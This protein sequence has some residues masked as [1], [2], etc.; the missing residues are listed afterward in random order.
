MNKDQVKGAAKDLGGKIQEEVGK[1]V[2][3]TEQQAKGL[4]HQAEGKVQ[5]HVGDLKENLKDASDAVQAALKPGGHQRS[6]VG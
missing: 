3:S 5:E 4:K 1:L 2:G 6:D